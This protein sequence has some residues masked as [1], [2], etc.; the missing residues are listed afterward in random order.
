M[1]EANVERINSSTTTVLAMF[2]S[3]VGGAMLTMPILFRSSGMITGSIIL[4]MSG[5]ISYV[6]CR[7]YVIHMADEDKDVEWTLRR[8]LGS[9]WEKRFRFITGF[10]L[11]LLCVIY[12]DLIVD[13]L[14]SIVFFFFDSNG[15][16]DLIAPK[17]GFMFS[18]F[19]TQYLTLILFVPLLLLVSIKNLN[20]MVKLSEYGSYSALLYFLFVVYK[21]CTALFNGEVNIDNVQLISWDVGNLAGTCALA[22]TVH[23]MVITFVK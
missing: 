5:I 20:V 3:M 9:K 16:A 10:Y 22:F 11:I 17:D 13:Q 8:L 7:I 18:K 23:T 19:S 12:I 2:N 14:Y 1:S 21:F 4:I 15:H 6:T